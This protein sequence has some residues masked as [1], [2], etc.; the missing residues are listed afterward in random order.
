MRKGFT[1]TEML[2]YI[3]ILA[4]LVVVLTQAFGSVLNTQLQSEAVSSVV[5]DTRYIFARLTYDLIRSGTISIPAAVGLSA[6]ILQIS[7]LGDTHIYSINAQGN[8]QLVNGSGTDLLNSF[9]T[10]V[11]NLN[12]QR[13]GNTGGKNSIKVSFTMTS[14]TRS[15]TG[16]ETKDVVTTIGTR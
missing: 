7:I 4:I 15:E 10:S 16:F 2:V 14:R 9:D 11:S 12:F 5:Q 8:M 13:L 6:N 3:S 1:L